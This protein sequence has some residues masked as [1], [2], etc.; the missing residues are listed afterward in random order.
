MGAANCETISG[1]VNPV[2]FEAQRQ[3]RPRPRAPV[4]GPTLGAS[5]VAL[6]RERAPA[7]PPSAG[8]SGTFLYDSS[9][10]GRRFELSVPRLRLARVGAPCPRLRFLPRQHAFFRRNIMFNLPTFS[11]SPTPDPSSAWYPWIGTTFRVHG[12]FYRNSTAWSS[13][14]GTTG[15][16]VSW[17]SVPQ[18]GGKIRTCSE[19]EMTEHRAIAINK[20]RPWSS[21]FAARAAFDSSKKPCRTAFLGGQF[22]KY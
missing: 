8:L 13:D 21:V 14:F 7:D 3:A 11:S 22:E 1:S 17:Y 4:R 2:T 5:G 16:R 10:E 18:A 19:F 12:V 6:H 9:L 15:R 20:C